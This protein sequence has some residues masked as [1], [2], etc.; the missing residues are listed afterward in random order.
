MWDG[1]LDSLALAWYSVKYDFVGTQDVEHSP[2]H[3]MTPQGSDEDTARFDRDKF[4]NEQILTGTM[5]GLGYAAHAAQDE[6]S[7]GHG[8]KVYD[9]VVT[10]EHIVKDAFPTDYQFKH[11]KEAT[12]DLLRRSGKCGCKP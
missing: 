8:F 3:S 7:G 9:G 6:F 11:A 2:M 12:R 10:P 1:E 4:I 5:E